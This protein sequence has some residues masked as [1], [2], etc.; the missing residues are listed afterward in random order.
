LGFFGILAEYERNCALERTQAGIAA[1][2]ALGRV[3]GK[4]S[5]EETGIPEHVIEKAKVAEILY[6]SK[7]I[8]T[9]AMLSN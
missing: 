1:A 6:T 5:W 2:R 7:G 9:S 4:R 8:T 3:G